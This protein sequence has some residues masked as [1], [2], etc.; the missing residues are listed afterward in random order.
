MSALHHL[1]HSITPASRSQQSALL[2]QQPASLPAS[3]VSLTQQQQQQQVHSPSLPF[4]PVALLPAA[5]GSIPGAQKEAAS[6]QVPPQA[7]Q[8]GA[9]TR[10]GVASQPTA[11]SRPHW[12][13][14]VDAELDAH[15]PNSPPLQNAASTGVQTLPLQQPNSHQQH[16][17]TH[18]AETSAGSQATPSN[19][20]DPLHS[21]EAGVGLSVPLWH[22]WVS[23]TSLTQ[24]QLKLI[25][26]AC[27]TVMTVA[28]RQ[29]QHE[30]VLPILES[31]KQ[32]SAHRSEH[33]ALSVMLC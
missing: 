24:Q 25:Q 6:S 26:E 22:K 3:S 9:E 11:P 12:R 16:Q 10:Q 21:K 20:A 14:W 4:P 33:T 13:S 1:L 27:H 23:S 31:M 30:L 18:E 15:R 8:S 19:G 29:Q 17:L 2:Q 32:V 5:L 7:L 28:E